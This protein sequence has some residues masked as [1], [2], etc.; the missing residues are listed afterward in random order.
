[1]RYFL[2]SGIVFREN[3]EMSFCTH[4]K[5]VNDCFRTYMYTITRHITSHTSP[6][7][8]KIIIIIL[9]HY[10]YFRARARTRTQIANRKIRCWPVY[11]LERYFV[12]NAVVSI[13]RWVFILVSSD[14]LLWVL[15]QDIRVMLEFDGSFNKWLVSNIIWWFWLVVDW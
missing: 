3:T 8:I 5:F 14:P 12:W 15:L 4:P 1:M 2:R 7:K 13:D 6:I 9:I 11:P 10:I